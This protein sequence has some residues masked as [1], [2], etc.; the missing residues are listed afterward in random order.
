MMLMCRT[1]A[2]KRTSLSVSSTSLSDMER[3]LTRF[4]AYFLPDDLRITLYTSPYAPLPS[5]PRTSKSASDDG[6]DRAV[7]GYRGKARPCSC[8]G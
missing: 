8:G 3:K 1:D 7:G 5:S 6:I 4:S 2:R